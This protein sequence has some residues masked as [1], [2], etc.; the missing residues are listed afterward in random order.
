MNSAPLPNEALTNLLIRVNTLE[1]QHGQIHSQVQ[2]VQAQLQQYHTESVPTTI[3]DYQL[4]SI[5]SSVERT[6]RDMVDVRREIADVRRELTELNAKF[7]KQV[8]DARTSQDQLQIKVL[9]GLVG[10]VITILTAV[11]IAFINHLIL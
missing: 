4:Q 2:Q 6:E 7:T 3:H 8:N 5:K 11:I 10:I 9:W 1:Q